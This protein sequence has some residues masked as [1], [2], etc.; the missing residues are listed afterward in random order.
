MHTILMIDTGRPAMREAA[1]EFAV[2]GNRV[3]ILAREVFALHGAQVHVVNLLDEQTN[4]ALVETLGQI[5]ILILGVPPMTEDG[6]IGTDHDTDAMLEEL[7]YMGQGTADVVEACL[8][9]MQSGM[10]RIACITERESSIGYARETSNMACH[11]ALA[12]LNMIGKELFNRLRPMGF[13]FRWYAA[14]EDTAPM[15]ASEYILSSLAL[16]PDE[17]ACHNEEDRLVMRDGFLQEI[18]W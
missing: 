1:R 10:K 4:R 6:A 17:P 2:A 3:H 14:D 16:H 11:M 18:P 5:D 8:P 12:G 13:S 15:H 7:V 9:V